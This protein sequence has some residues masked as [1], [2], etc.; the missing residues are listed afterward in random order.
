ML[1]NE[2]QL[3]GRLNLALHYQQWA[4]FALHLA[5]LSP[6]VREQAAFCL[7]DQAD[8]KAAPELAQQLGVRTERD[9]QC[10][11]ADL[12]TLAK[13]QQA[14]FAGGLASMRLQTLLQPTPTVVRNDP[15]KI[16]ADVADNL[17]LHTIRHF[18]ASLPPQVDVDPTLLYDVL[19]QLDGVADA[20]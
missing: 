16:G 19:Q 12:S 18:Q 13:Q 6:D 8:S 4:D 5:L 15:K 11:E 3:K 17:D 2:W 7:N 14:L 1:I 10:T 9:F 20:A